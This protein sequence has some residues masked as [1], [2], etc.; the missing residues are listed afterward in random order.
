VIPV[1]F[2]WI[3]IIIVF[4]F[5]GLAR[6]LWK[7]IGVTTVMLLSLF[8][9]YMGEKLVLEALSSR[10][11]Q[12]MLSNAPGGT[13]AAIYY[14]VTVSFVAFIAYQGITLEFPIK[15][16]TGLGKWIFGFAGGLFNGYLIA[17]TIWNVVSRADHFGIKVPNGSTGTVTQ[18]SQTLTTFDQSIVRFLPISIL[19][20]NDLIPYVFL[21]LGMLLLIAIILK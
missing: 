7:E 9:L 6:G 5:I 14:G 1:G 4:G 20:A 8:A 15:K 11:P 21:G 2:L 18:I 13:I 12:G 17:G 19:H 16:R 10:L 3:A